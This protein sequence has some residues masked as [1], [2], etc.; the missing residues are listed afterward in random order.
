MPGSYTVTFKSVQDW[1]KPDDITG[2]EVVAD[3]PTGPIYANYVYLIKYVSGSGDNDWPGTAEQPYRSIQKGVD[4]VPEGGTVYVSGGAG[5]FLK[6][7]FPNKALTLTGQSNPVVSG[8]TIYTVFTLTNITK[9][10]TIENFTLEHGKSTAGGGM[11]IYNSSPTIRYCT[12]QDNQAYNNSGEAYGGGLCLD[13][14]G[15]TID[16]C[17]FYNNLADGWYGEVPH[18]RGYGGAVLAYNSTTTFSYCEFGEPPDDD[19]AYTQTIA[20]GVSEELFTWVYN[21]SSSTVPTYTN[22]KVRGGL[23][24]SGDNALDGPYHDYS[25]YK[26]SGSGN[27]DF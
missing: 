19:N 2:I 4:E 23:P 14:A 22:C 1:A 5:T 20:S 17:Y 11:Y 13:Y 6:V 8:S 25:G 9:S 12:F 7:V 26:P 15:G 16:H 10:I 27:S 3:Q 21:A 18:T 24:G